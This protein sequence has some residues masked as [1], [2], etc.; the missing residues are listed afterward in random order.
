MSL[1]ELWSLCF[2]VEFTSCHH[3][4]RMNSQVNNLQAH[5]SHHTTTNFSGHNL[6]R[7]QHH[8]IFCCWRKTLFLMS[9][10]LLSPDWHY[11]ATHSTVW[12]FLWWEKSIK[13]ENNSAK[14]AG[15]CVLLH[16]TTDWTTLFSIFS[17]H[18]KPEFFNQNIFDRRLSVTTTSEFDD[19]RLSS[20]L[21][22]GIWNNRTSCLHLLQMKF[23]CYMLLWGSLWA[24]WYW[25]GLTSSKKKETRQ[26]LVWKHLGNCVACSDEA[27]W[28][29]KW[30]LFFSSFSVV[31]VDCAVYRVS[32]C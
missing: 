29:T 10:L 18:N 20:S 26:I 13:H 32:S 12:H 27:G 31:V 19:W 2:Q 14:V 15:T 21:V 3:A 5:K 23:S 30:N 17:A 6:T 4:T 1:F 8:H 28:S 22:C 25:K 7:V 11:D 9:A 16:P 24:R